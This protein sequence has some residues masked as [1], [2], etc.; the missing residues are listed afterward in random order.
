MGPKG[1]KVLHVS[2]LPATVEE[3]YF[4]HAEVVGDV[5]PSLMLLADRLEGKLKNAGAL[6]PLRSGTGK[7][8]DASASQTAGGSSG[9][10]GQSGQPLWNLTC[11]ISSRTAFM[12]PLFEM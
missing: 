9:F 7:R 6:L 4:P 11:V 10:G 1:P 3:V 5:G 8:P 2:Y 12:S